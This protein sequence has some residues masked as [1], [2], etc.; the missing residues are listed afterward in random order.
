MTRKSMSVVVVLVAVLAIGAQVYTDVSH[1]QDAEKATKKVE[2]VRKKPRGRLPAYY[3]QVGLS[4]KQ[5][6]DIYAA[7]AQFNEQIE[8][9]RKQIS[10]LEEKRDADVKAVLTPE[11]AK[12][13]DDLLAAAKKRAEE[14]RKARSS[15]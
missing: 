14:R 15:K 1:A 7:Q 11:Q 5:R 6:D 13:L 4:S 8:V 10:V 9:L 3:G 12:T 2:A